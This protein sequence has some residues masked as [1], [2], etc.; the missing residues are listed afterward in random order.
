MKSKVTAAELARIAGVTAS[1]VREYAKELRELVQEEVVPGLTSGRDSCNSHGCAWESH[2]A[3]CEKS[4][5]GPG[6]LPDV[7]ST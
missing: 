4:Q 2:V 1:L 5:R 6:N 7:L 3:A